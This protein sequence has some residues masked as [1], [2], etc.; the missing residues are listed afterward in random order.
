MVLNEKYEL[1]KSILSEMGSVLVAYS[2]GVDSTFLLRTAHDVLDSSCVA[3]T[4]ASPLSPESEL[5][6]AASFCAESGIEHILYAFDPFTVEHFPENPPDRCYYCK[7]ALFSRFVAIA[8]ERGLA[9]VAEGSNLDDTGDYRP[10]MRAV[11]EQKIRSPLLEAGLRKSEIRELSKALG[12]QTWNKPSCAC[13]ASRF[14]YGDTITQEGL[15][16]V[17]RAEE[18]LRTLG[19]TQLRVRV[20]GSLARIEVPTAEM[21][22]ALYN[23]QEIETSL[24][25]LGFLYVT[26][27]LGGF[28]SGSMNRAL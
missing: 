6:S 8:G 10:G 18:K 28:R 27:D 5:R 20:H 12:L 19:F 2:A 26:L 17:G 15:D 24:R 7:S 3:V 14:P 23:A 11:Q 21:K 9:C 22:T 25:A 16:R 1:L 4:A 13:L